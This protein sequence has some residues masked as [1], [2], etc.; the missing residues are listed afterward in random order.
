MSKTK[1]VGNPPTGKKKAAKSGTVP[2]KSRTEIVNSL[3]ET[4]SRKT[5]AQGSALAAFWPQLDRSARQFVVSYLA[6]YTNS[7]PKE[8]DGEERTKLNRTILKATK[9]QIG[10]LKK[11]AS[12]REI[13]QK[14]RDARGRKV[15]DLEPLSYPQGT[16]FSLVLG[17]E[18]QRLEGIAMRFR[19]ALREKHLGLAGSYLQLVWA[20]DFVALWATTMGRTVKLGP[21]E[22][23]A[24]IEILEAERGF[25]ARDFNREDNLSKAI[26][27]F[28]A[29]RRNAI[30]LELLRVRV[31]HDVVHSIVLKLRH[32]DS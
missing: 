6:V 8:L 3:I 11:A 12:D 27:R 19:S 25:G 20:Q 7:I 9:H 21:T 22:L 5:M 28:R 15:S 24:L 14:I 30:Y 32:E 1:S 29:N 10:L 2:E 4:I 16:E 26:S 31:A 13:F 23:A 17:Y 18:V